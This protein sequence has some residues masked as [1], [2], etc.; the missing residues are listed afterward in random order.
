MHPSQQNKAFKSKHATKG[1]MKEAAKGR[2][3]RPSPKASATASGAQLRL[4]RRNQA[5][6]AQVQ[7]RQALV[8]ATRVFS[9]AD[10]APRIVAIVPLSGD[11]DARE[12]ARAL[13]DAVDGGESRR[14][15]EHERT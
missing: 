11:V 2:L 14:H 6:Q 8:S 1:S 15:T 7:K 5:K 10:G 3:S 12:V 13:G 9:G 4:N